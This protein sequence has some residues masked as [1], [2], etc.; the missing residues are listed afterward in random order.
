MAQRKPER[1][2]DSRAYRGRIERELVLGGIAITIVLGGGLIAL[3]WG[4][5]AFFTALACF[6]GALGIGALIWLFL[7]LLELVSRD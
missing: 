1:L 7:K 3:I 5:D 2:F 6:V 4:R